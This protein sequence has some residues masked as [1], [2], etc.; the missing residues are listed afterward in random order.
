MPQSDPVT[1]LPTARRETDHRV[2]VRDLMLTCMIGVHGHERRARQR[3]RVNLTL[4]VASSAK[5]A[6]DALVGVVDY[7]TIVDGIRRIAEEGHINLVETLAERIA[8]LA[9]ADRRV[10]A[11]TVRV[12]K[13]DVFADVASVGV[14]LTRRR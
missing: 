5:A 8:D 12:E 6:A 4:D 14:E 1:P 3:V 2:F 7:E 10:L 13:I 9:L 11:A